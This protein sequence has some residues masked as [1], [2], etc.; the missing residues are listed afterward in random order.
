VTSFGHSVFGR[1]MWFANG[2]PTTSMSVLR[3][4]LHRCRKFQT[5]VRMLGEF[6]GAFPD[7]FGSVSLCVAPPYSPK[8]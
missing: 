1:F 3:S 8:R 7:R 2:T 6:V 4:P 5:A